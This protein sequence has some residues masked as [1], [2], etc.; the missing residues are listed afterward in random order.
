MI[1]WHCPW[2]SEERLVKELV[3]TVRKTPDGT[4]HSFGISISLQDFQRLP[5]NCEVK[6]AITFEWRVEI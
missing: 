3:E 5:Q 6:S 1:S 2:A 4:S